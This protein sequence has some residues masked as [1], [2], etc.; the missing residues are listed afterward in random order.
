LAPL[1]FEFVPAQKQSTLGGLPA[2]EALAQRFDLW[3][4]LRTLPGLDPWVRT[5][6]G[7]NPELIVGQWLYALGSGGGGLA[8]AERLNDEPLAHPLARVEHFADQT[9]LGEWLRKQTDAS[10]A[11]V[12]GFIREFVQWVIGPGAP[13]FKPIS[14][15]PVLT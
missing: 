2:R 5:T 11:A 12:W 1:R 15:G 4:K 3:V 10:I 6:Q 8:D 7:Y 13:R 9:Q 14:C